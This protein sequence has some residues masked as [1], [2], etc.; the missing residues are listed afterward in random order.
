METSEA[1]Q[2][3]VDVMAP[4]IGD[5]MARSATEAHCQKLGIPTDSPLSSEH[6]ESLL[7]KLSGGLNI[8]LGREKA[9]AVIADVRSA[10]VGREGGR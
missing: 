1:L 3:I 2:V 10:L 6:L 8:F 7:G 5:T 9:A 4:Y